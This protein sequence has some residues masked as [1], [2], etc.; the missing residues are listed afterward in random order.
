MWVTAPHCCIPTPR[1]SNLEPLGLDPSLS[2]SYQFP[3]DTHPPGLVTMLWELLRNLPTLFPCMIPAPPSWTH[4]SFTSAGCLDGLN[5]SIIHA[6]SFRI[7]S[8]FSTPN[9]INHHLCNHL[10]VFFP[11][12]PWSP[13]TKTG[14][15]HLLCLKPN[16]IAWHRVHF[17][18][19]DEWKGRSPAS[20]YLPSKFLGWL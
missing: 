11:T 4:R 2:I 7:L 13:W 18:W 14:S 12:I 19:L 15:V 1:A 9:I 5:F 17:H 10:P 16:T 6:T 8:C 20:I 3:P